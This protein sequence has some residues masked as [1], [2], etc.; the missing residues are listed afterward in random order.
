MPET[1]PIRPTD[2][3]ARRLARTLL[4]AAKFAAIGVVDPATAMPMVSRIAAGTDQGIPITLI[5]ELSHHTKALRNNPQCSLLVGEPGDKGDPLTH[6]RL[7]LQ[8][9]AAF[10]ARDTDE[11]DT[12]RTLWLNHQPKA[13]LYIDFTDFSFVRFEPTM[14]YLNGGFGKAFVLTADDLAPR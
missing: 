1:S 7:T 10:V 2:E 6:P 14:A 4:C 13:K 12:L 9:T 3:E 11:H 5:S 8:A